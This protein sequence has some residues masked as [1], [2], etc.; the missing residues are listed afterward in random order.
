MT[1]QSMPERLRPN[2][3]SSFIKDSADLLPADPSASQS[4]HPFSRLCSEDGIHPFPFL[5]QSP[6]TL[7][8]PRRVEPYLHTVYPVAVQRLIR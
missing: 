8:E 4:F 7:L 2:R 3:V 1:A 6:R 5:L